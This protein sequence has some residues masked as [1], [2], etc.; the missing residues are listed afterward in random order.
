MDLIKLFEF[1]RILSESENFIINLL[2]RIFS[3][4]SNESNLNNLMSSQ[5]TRDFI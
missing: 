3:S 2:I 5:R 4:G 1:F